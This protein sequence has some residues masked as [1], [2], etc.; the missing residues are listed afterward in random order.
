[1]DAPIRGNYYPGM[2]PWVLQAEPK[3]KTHKRYWRT[4]KDHMYSAKQR[5]VTFNLTFG[6]W[7][8]IWEASGQLDNRG[9]R[10]GQY[11]MGRYNDKGA[12]EV[13]NVKIILA[14]VNNSEGNLGRVITPA[15]KAKFSA[16]VTGRKMSFEHRK[17]ISK[18]LKGHVTTEA[19]RKKIGDA[20]RGK[21]NTTEARAKIS[22]AL[23]GRPWSP[24]RRAACESN[25]K[26][27]LR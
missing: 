8:N 2:A 16:T 13:G 15:Q 24:L 17:A 11:V 7:I 3:L 23:K 9:R 22:K 14:S 5:G 19:T 1:M 6:Q 27:K 4:Y 25:R 18:A 12:Y 21:S 20:H 10:V 26:N